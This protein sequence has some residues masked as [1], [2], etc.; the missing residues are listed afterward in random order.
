MYYITAATRIPIY[1]NSIICALM[2]WERYIMVCHATDYPVI[3]SDQK[4]KRIYSIVTLIITGFFLLHIL[5][6]IIES[7]L[8]NDDVR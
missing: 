6:A 5:D 2:A 8:D 3:L 1:S 7:I 4:R